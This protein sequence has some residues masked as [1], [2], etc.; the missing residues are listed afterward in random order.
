MKGK[1]QNAVVRLKDF[2]KTVSSFL[3]TSIK[4]FRYQWEKTQPEF[5]N[6]PCEDDF[7]V[8]EGLT[9]FSVRKSYNQLTKDKVRFTSTAMVIETYG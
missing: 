4:A 6:P 3:N 8:L 9:L 7:D 2:Q 5:N 1:D